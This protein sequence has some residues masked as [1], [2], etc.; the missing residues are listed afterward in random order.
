MFHPPSASSEAATSL[1]DFL[2]NWTKSEFLYSCFTWYLNRDCL[3]SNRTFVFSSCPKSRT[4][5][6]LCPAQLINSPSQLS[7]KN[8]VKIHW[9]HL[10]KHTA[11]NLWAPNF[12]QRYKWSVRRINPIKTLQFNEQSLFHFIYLFLWCIVNDQIQLIWC[13]KKVL[14]Q[15][16]A[17]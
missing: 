10:N 2:H 8:L 13:D 4:F 11:Q 7:Q 15:P 6:P 1:T 12:L 14:D 17:L 3:S 16:I 5:V 9:S